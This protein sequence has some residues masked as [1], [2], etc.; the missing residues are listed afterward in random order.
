MNEHNIGNEGT[1][2][3]NCKIAAKV[4]V[5]K[6]LICIP[7]TGH[8]PP[9]K[10][11]ENYSRKLHYQ[12]WPKLIHT[13]T[14]SSMPKSILYQSATHSLQRLQFPSMVT[15][16]KTSSGMHVNPGSDEVLQLTSSFYWNGLPTLP[17][18]VQLDQTD[19][20][21]S[22]SPSLPPKTLIQLGHPKSAQPSKTWSR[23]KRSPG[24]IVCSSPPITRA[25]AAIGLQ[26]SPAHWRRVGQ[27]EK[28]LFKYGPSMIEPN[29]F[30]QTHK[31]NY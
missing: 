25:V 10:I 16:R 23:C 24:Q 26:Q 3:W 12:D 19:G 14:Q 4:Y 2:Q 27:E 7:E 21:S 30:M 13:F 6:R 20:H 31:S 17:K 9:H 15:S 28:V 1:V 5:S 11:D 18:H 8:H 29:D 22:I